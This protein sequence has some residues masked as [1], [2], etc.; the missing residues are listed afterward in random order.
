MLL[1]PQMFKRQF[2]VTMKISVF[3]TRRIQ[4]ISYTTDVFIACNSVKCI[5]YCNIQCSSAR[6]ICNRELI[7]QFFIISVLH[8]QSDCQLQIQHKIRT[9]I[10]NITKEQYNNLIQFLILPNQHKKIKNID[11]ETK[12]CLHKQRIHSRTKY[13]IMRRVPEVV[14]V[15]NE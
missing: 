3:C 6:T 11:Q 15:I 2:P 12:Q 5:V 13:I 4:H 10:I 8:Q 7:I 9:K 1:V 14:I